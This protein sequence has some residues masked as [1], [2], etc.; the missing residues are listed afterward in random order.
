ML[1]AW[2]GFW[3][4]WA[5][6][7]KVTFDG[8]EKIIFINPGVNVL[9]TKRDLYSAWKEWVR[10]GR[11]GTYARA[12]TAIGGQE[13][14]EGSNLGTTYFLENGWRIKPV[15][16][17]YVLTIEGNLFTRESG[18]NPTIPTSGVSVSLSRSNIVDLVLPPKQEITVET[19]PDPDTELRL[20]E[21][22][23][24]LGLD[25]ASPE[26]IRDTSITVGDIT[27]SITRDEQAG[28]TVL[29]RE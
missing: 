10:V 25:S 4:D 8:P 9:S 15:E 22:W 27:L 11:N 20:L 21:I 24:F 17:D 3:E 5:L 12:F 6:R 28:T 14:A 18:E 23:R 7:H 2:F 26:T 19:N 16:G 13:I 29:E 1:A